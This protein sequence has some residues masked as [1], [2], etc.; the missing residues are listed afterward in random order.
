LE[1]EEKEERRPIFGRQDVSLSIPQD[2]VKNL[3][4]LAEHL[5]KHSDRSARVQRKLYPKFNVVVEPLTKLKNPRAAAALSFKEK[6]LAKLPRE[7]I[8]KALVSYGEKLLAK[9]NT[10]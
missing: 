9:N 4:T 10:N 6:R 1:A 2:E 8:A 7:N 5:D 3:E